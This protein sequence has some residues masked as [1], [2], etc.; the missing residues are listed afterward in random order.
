MGITAVTS[1]VAFGPVPKFR[2]GPR[3]RTFARTI[4]YVLIFAGGVPLYYIVHFVLGVHN[5]IASLVILAL[6]TVIIL[7]QCPG[8]ALHPFNAAITFS[9]MSRFIHLATTV[10]TPEWIDTFGYF[11]LIP[12]TIVLTLPLEDFL[13]YFYFLFSAFIGTLCHA[14][15][16]ARVVDCACLSHALLH[17]KNRTIAEIC[18][19]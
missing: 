19:E 7:R 15:Y 11:E 6:G 2:I 10:I 18:R 12:R 3:Q 14:W 17:Q 13:F 5:I 8:L 16:G 1:H 4:G 9:I